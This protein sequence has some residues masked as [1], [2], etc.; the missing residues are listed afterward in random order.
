MKPKNA[1]DILMRK[2][3][4]PP[5]DILPK[6]KLMFDGGSRGNPGLCG[7][8]VVIYRDDIEVSTISHF[9]PGKHTNNF[10]EYTAF[11]IGMEK[12]HQLNITSLYVEGDSKLVI[13]QCLG[14]WQTKSPQLIHLNN[15]AKNLM[16]QFEYIHLE[17]ILR[18]YN[19]RA[20][21]LANI[22][23]DKQ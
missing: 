20:D 22:A 23:M 17:H 12:A 9:I 4:T 7:A 3:I 16:I 19:K 15:T 11:I 6:Y 1:F 14:K 5:E 13:N 18:N 8:G 2:H 21:Q 10:A